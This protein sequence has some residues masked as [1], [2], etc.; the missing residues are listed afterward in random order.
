MFVDVIM[1]P[2]TPFFPPVCVQTE[3]KAN[4]TYTFK[5]NIMKQ[6]GAKR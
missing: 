2:E 5:V 3:G 1:S 6:L 4:L